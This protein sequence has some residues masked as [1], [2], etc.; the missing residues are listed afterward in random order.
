MAPARK[1]LA[2]PSGPE[3]RYFIVNP[4][5]C[6]HEVDR[7]HAAGRLKKSPGWRMAT[8][9]EV[10]LLSSDRRG[11]NGTKIASGEQRYDAPICPP[12]TPDPDAQ[13]DLEAA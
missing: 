8:K 2:A 5:G 3:R 4:A 13:I 12:W 11:P 1:P 6:I 7:D 9:E 10:A